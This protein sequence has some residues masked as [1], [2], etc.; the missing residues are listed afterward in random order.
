MAVI[1]LAFQR[2]GDLAEQ[3]TEILVLID[4]TEVLLVADQVSLQVDALV[5]ADRWRQGAVAAVALPCRRQRDGIG[6]SR[7]DTVRRAAIVDHVLL[8]ADRAGDVGF[9]ARALGA[10]A[11]EDGVDFREW[12]A[13]TDAA[14]G[15]LDLVAA[16]VQRRRFRRPQVHFKA[17]RNAIVRKIRIGLRKRDRA[18][19]MAG[20]EFNADRVAATGEVCL[21]NRCR[22]GEFFR[23]RKGAAD[24]EVTRWFFHHRHVDVD[25]VGRALR[26]RRVDGH[27]LEVAQAVDTVARQLDLVAVVPGR[28][29]LAEFAA[30]DFI[31]RGGVAGDI[32]VAHVHALARID[33]ESKTH[34]MLVTVDFG[35]GID[36]GKRIA[37]RGQ[38]VLDAFIRGRQAR[39][40]V[41]LAFAHQ[42]QRFQ[43]FFAAEHLAFELGAG[44][45]VLFTF[46]DIDRQVDIFFI[47]RDR[48]LRGVDLHLDIATIQV[49][50][51]QRLDVARQLG[52]RILVGLR[53]PAEPAARVQG[54]LIAQFL[55]R[56]GLVADD[57]DLLDAGHVALVDGEHH[58]DAVAL[59][60]RDGGGDLHAVQAMRQVLALELLFR[61]VDRSLVEN[62]R[63]ADADFLQS[64]DQHIFFKFL[65]A[66]E[67][68]GSDGRA[69][70]D[71]HHQHVA[72]DFQAHVLEKT[73]RV[74]GL[75]GGDT[76]LVGER[77]ADAHR[78]IAENSTRFSTLDPF[79]P[80]VLDSKWLD[81]QR[82]AGTEGHDGGADQ[83]ATKGRQG[84][85]SRM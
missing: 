84:K 79:D 67:F 47:G 61:A 11:E 85:T 68:H 6:G 33:E 77:F 69:L 76:L 1:E 78:Q 56:E 66:R 12:H 9:D 35:I 29:E 45:L 16:D 48:H 4:G 13:E 63:F 15:L 20:I 50:G 53:V 21:R 72:I 75:D 80:D 22:Q 82:M 62:L 49:V 60:R 19:V 43:L 52:L 58:V 37:E 65:G 18:A 71:Q 5:A 54:Q 59:D 25:L 3:R 81:G 23:L 42:V 70:L 46:G 27:V 64:L 41:N 8:E 74:Q 38:A 26:F 36:V 39:A 24:Q 57:V 73:R 44:D 55:V 32:H 10:D 83:A 17:A 14:T 2:Q 40:R 30:D 31:A 51:L 7:T 34:F 28:F